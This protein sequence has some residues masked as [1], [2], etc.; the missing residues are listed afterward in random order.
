MLKQESGPG[1]GED[2]NDAYHTV[3]GD[4]IIVKDSCIH[5]E[6]ISSCYIQVAGGSNIGF[7]G[8]L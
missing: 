5:I 1:T 3:V 7:S 2:K 6:Y 8:R 4:G